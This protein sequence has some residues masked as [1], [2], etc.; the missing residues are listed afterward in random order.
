M[1]DRPAPNQ[2]PDLGGTVSHALTSVG[3]CCTLLSV[4]ATQ[5]RVLE[6]YELVQGIKQRIQTIDADLKAAM[7]E[8]INANGQ[9]QYGT[10]RF[11]VGTKK[12]T[13]NTSNTL[14]IVNAVLN[15]SGGDI[16]PVVNAMVANPFKKSATQEILGDQW[17]E[18]FEVVDVPDLCEGKAT[19]KP[20]KE[21]KIAD[22]RFLPQKE[23]V[24][25]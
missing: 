1:S 23:N 20:V 3:F 13:V 19:G 25:A 7:I 4:D 5:D 8:W 12:T 21:L 14:A 24:N 2:S 15:A 16:E 22:K 11:Y 18:H 9:I 10:K 6:L 17:G